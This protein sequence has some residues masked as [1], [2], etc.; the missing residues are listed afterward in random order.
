MN[1][2]KRYVEKREIQREAERRNKESRE[3]C[4]NQLWEAEYFDSSGNSLGTLY[5]KGL[6]SEILNFNGGHRLE[7]WLKSDTII[8]NNRIY[9]TQGMSMSIPKPISD[10]P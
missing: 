1:I 7:L 4:A 6:N 3:R 9:K 2:F 5:A 8:I 10:N